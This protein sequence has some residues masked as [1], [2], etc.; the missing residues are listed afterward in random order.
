[1][2]QVDYGRTWSTTTP[3]IAGLIAFDHHVLLLF[4]PPFRRD[5]DRPRHRVVVKAIHGV[6]VAIVVV[7]T[8]FILLLLVHD[9]VLL[10]I[11]VEMSTRRG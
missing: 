9:Q 8:E 10:L 2:Q 4:L 1:L 11:L 7:F 5:T 3:V 6:I